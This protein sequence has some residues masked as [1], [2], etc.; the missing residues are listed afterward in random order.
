MQFPYTME[1]QTS[2]PK[3]PVIEICFERR[4]DPVLLKE[5]YSPLSSKIWFFKLR[6]WWSW[7]VL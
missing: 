7:C 2:Q 1:I 3:N 5:T 6:S 4:S